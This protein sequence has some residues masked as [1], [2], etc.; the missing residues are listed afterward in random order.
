MSAPAKEKRDSTTKRKVVMRARP[1]FH[2]FDDFCALVPDGQKAD[3]IDGVIH[4]A[5]PDS[6]ENDDLG[7]WFLRLLG[8]FVDVRDLGKVTGSRRAYKL[9]D[10]NSPEPD[11]AV[12]HKKRLHLERRR[13]FLGAPDLAVEI[14]S[15]DS[16]DRDYEK[17]RRLYEEAGVSEYWIIDQDIKQVMLLRLDSKGQYREVKPKKGILHSQVLPGF[18]IR[19][20]W[21]WKE[22]RPSKFA[23]LKEI[24]GE[25]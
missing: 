22:T 10:A 5:S 6:M 9:D 20:E 2:T 23:A 14:V 13:S 19:V 15:P 17:K 12:V 1:G 24:L 11:I 16:V 7:T 18:W 25:E 4:M 21:L 3:L 8:D